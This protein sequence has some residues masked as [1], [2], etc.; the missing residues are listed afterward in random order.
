[1]STFAEIFE[2]DSNLY[3]KTN[4]G[5]LNLKRRSLNCLRSIKCKYLSDLLK[6]RRNDIRKF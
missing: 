3:T 1:M 5:E 6:L 2:L 4:I